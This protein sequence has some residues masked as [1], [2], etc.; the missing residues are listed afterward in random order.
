MKI[1][2]NAITA[3]SPPK[4]EFPRNFRLSDHLRPTN[5]KAVYEFIGTGNFDAAWYAR[6][7]YE[8]E[9]G[10]QEVPILY[11]VLYNTITDP[12][13]PKNVTVYGIGPGGVF[14]QEIQEGG[15]VKFMTVGESQK[16]ITLAHYGVGLEYSDDLVAFNELWSVAIA[17]RAVGQAYNGL[18]NNAH[19]SPIIAFAYQAANQTAANTDGSTF[20]EDMY[21]TF[22]DAITN[23]TTDT[24]NPRRGPY[25]ILCSTA[26]LFDI[27]R[28]LTPEV[29]SQLAIQNGS[30]RSMI[31]GII[32]YDSQ[33][34]TMGNLSVTYT[35]VTAGKAY[36]ISTQYQAK[37]FQSFIKQGLEEYGR[38]ED[39]SRFLLQV[40]W[41][42]RFGVYAN[43]VA[44]VEEVTLPTPA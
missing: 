39:V 38:Q 41:D 6:Q 2:T 40:V 18:L 19:L 35:G 31:R 17:E 24:A 20:T 44:A 14:L 9:M 4:R 22:E 3:A 21:L 34:F 13:L 12:N 28:A 29:Q 11:E 32:A 8:V 5:N 25:W 26:D 15:E 10:R 7:Q 30:A 43:P 36:L 1:L 23:S 42:T 37:D 27:Q 33:T 16:A